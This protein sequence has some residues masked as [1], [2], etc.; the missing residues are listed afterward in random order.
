MYIK[1]YN[2]ITKRFKTKNR[3]KRKFLLAGLLNVLITNIFLQIFLFTNLF[4]ITVSTFLSQLINMVLGY[5]IYSKFIFNVDK[6]IKFNFLK[7]YFLLMLFLWLV[8]NYGIKFG[9]ILGISNNLSA[10]FLVPILA[11]V[12]FIIQKLWV[13]RKSN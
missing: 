4:N 7:K 2:L 3:E 13:F 10:F 6:I 1:V 5:I 8:N 12:S 9:S 11:I